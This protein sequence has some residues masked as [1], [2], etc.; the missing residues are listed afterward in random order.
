LFDEHRLGERQGWKFFQFRLQG[1]FIKR[2]RIELLRDERVNS[3][4]LHA[5]EIAGPR[6]ERE[7]V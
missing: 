7:T 4:G 1:A 6:A 3:H 5:L 2:I